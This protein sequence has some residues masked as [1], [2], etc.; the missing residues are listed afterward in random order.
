MPAGSIA[1]PAAGSALADLIGLFAQ[2]FA[3]VRDRPI[4]FAAVVIVSTGS[5]AAIDLAPDDLLWPIMIL[6]SLVSVYLLALLNASALGL[7]PI[8]AV[9]RRFISVAGLTV[10]TTAGVLVGLL[11]LVI[12]ALVMLVRWSVAMPV[13][14]VEEQGAYESMERS[15]ELTANHRLL[16]AG[17]TGVLILAFF[18]SSL[19]SLLTDYSALPV[20]ILLA[21]NF[22]SSLLAAFDS[23]LCVAL[24]RLI[25]SRTSPRSLPE[26][27]S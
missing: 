2:A 1:T 16:A 11:L 4:L 5:G 6:S 9:G 15:W 12:P 18:P 21:V 7:D 14:L 23:L 19:L 13:M 3:F 10:L 22:Y 20:P 17:V 25:L 27:F 8:A 24:Y 26:I